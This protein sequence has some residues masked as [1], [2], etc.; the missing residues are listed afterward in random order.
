MG[1]A[2][3]IENIGEGTSVLQALQAQGEY[4]LAPCG[5]NGTCGKCRVRFVQNP[6]APS[7]ADRKVL[8][9]AEIAN[10]CTW[11]PAFL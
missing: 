5:G 1:H 7:Q 6:P 2:I 10:R 4:I 8:T 3:R 11:R 9:E